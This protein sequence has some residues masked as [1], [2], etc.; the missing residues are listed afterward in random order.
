MIARCLALLGL[1][2]LTAC[3][4][5]DMS[6]PPADLGDFRLGYNIVQARDVEQGP[7]SRS[8]T[9]AELTETLAR[10]VEARLGRY[11]GDGLYHIGIA[12]GAYVLAQPGLPVIYTPKSV[13]F[14]DVN[15]YD[16]ATGQ[17]LNDRPERITAFEG[18]RNVA[19]LVGSGLVRDKD[20][21][22]Q[23]LA[24]EAARGVEAWLRRN[25][26]WFVPDPGAPRVTFDRETLDARAR[27]ALAAME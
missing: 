7:F 4:G 27:A 26:E 6:E 24:S 15:V 17:R 23:N 12:I 14:I 8:A 11:D 25:P 20:A 18:L 19:P 3:G 5:G 16:D 1:V 10:A 9:E 22:L 2:L 21:Q 13:L